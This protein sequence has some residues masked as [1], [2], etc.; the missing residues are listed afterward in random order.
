MRNPRRLAISR[1]LERQLRDQLALDL[2]GDPDD[3]HTQKAKYL[4]DQLDKAQA[5]RKE[6]R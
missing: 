1:N 2:Q 5:G 3:S 6:K 4:L